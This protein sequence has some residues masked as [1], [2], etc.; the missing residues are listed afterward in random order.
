MA[1]MYKAF[2]ITIN[3]EHIHCVHNIFV[4]NVYAFHYV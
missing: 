4:L 1:A 3:D 2:N